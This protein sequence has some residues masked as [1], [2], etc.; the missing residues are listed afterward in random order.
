MS[1]ISL[2][3]TIIKNWLHGEYW[4]VHK[5]FVNFLSSLPQKFKSYGPSSNLSRISSF[6]TK[7]TGQKY[8]LCNNYELYDDL[9]FWTSSCTLI[10][11]HRQLVDQCEINARF[12][13]MHKSEE[14]LVRLIQMLR[15]R[16]ASCG[17]Q[18]GMDRQLLEGCIEKIW[19]GYPIRNRNWSIGKRLLKTRNPR[20]PG[21][22]RTTFYQWCQKH[23]DHTTVPW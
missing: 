20:P 4:I 22:K 19:Q 13:W 8:L 6:W 1:I 3:H 11:D 10:K 12:P 14:C 7:F 23:T 15:R 5:F 2:L 9:T 21:W 17:Y 18:M 16:N